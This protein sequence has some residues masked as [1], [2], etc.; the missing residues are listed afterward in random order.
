MEPSNIPNLI[1]ELSRQLDDRIRMEYEDERTRMIDVIYNLRR[2]H[3]KDHKTSIFLK[4]KFQSLSEKCN[5]LNPQLFTEDKRDQTEDNDLIKSKLSK[6]IELKKADENNLVNTNIS[7]ENLNV[8]K[9]PEKKLNITEEKEQSSRIKN[10]VKKPKYVDV[11]R[12]KSE[13]ELLPGFECEE[14][15]NYFKALQQQGI[16]SSSNKA[17]FLQQCSRHKSR[18]TPP[19]TPDGYWDLSI[20]DNW[21]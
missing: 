2:Q 20:K 5:K 17:E 13:R 1:Y 14:C 11:V 4:R 21:S 9:I 10:I 19:S 16:F 6:E 8:N 3:E 7:N 12:K 18:F 15:R